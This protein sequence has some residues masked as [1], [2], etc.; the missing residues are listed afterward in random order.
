MKELR[1]QALLALL[2][3]DPPSKCLAAHNL[4]NLLGTGAMVLDTEQLIPEPPGVPGHPE[5]PELIAPH[6]VPRRRAGSAAGRAALLHAVA[7]IE[8]NAINLALDAIWRFP[9]M[10]P[11]FY[12]DWLHVASEEA[13]HFGL[14]LKRLGAYGLEYG[15]LP[16]HNGLWEAAHKTRLDLLA[17]MALVP[18]TLEARG[19]DVTPALRDKLADAGDL[20]SAAVL[21]V[22]LR[23]EV[24]HVAIGNRWYH[25]LCERQGRSSLTAHAEVARRYDAGL[26][27]PP[28]NWE[29]RQRAGFNEA[30]LLYFQDLQPPR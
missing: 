16:A 1:H 22:I 14:L 8:F 25:F 17:R 28:F 2:E 4:Y 27:R 19:L 6:Q 13:T 10:P 15:D 23:D 18:R 29:A 7:H 5:R 30:D 26:P 20:D 24:G 21:D 11:A 3:P 9:S 12:H